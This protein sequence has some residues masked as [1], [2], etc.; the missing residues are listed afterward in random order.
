M[1]FRP[2]FHG[3][4]PLLGGGVISVEVYSTQSRLVVNI[5]DNGVGMDEEQLRILRDKLSS[6]SLTPLSGVSSRRGTGLALMNVNARIQLAYGQQFG[7]LVFSTKGIG[8]QFQVTL[9]I[10]EDWYE[11]GSPAH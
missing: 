1:R 6:A 7:L 5:R 3:I 8:T 2:I 4:E 9:P 10:M 11:N